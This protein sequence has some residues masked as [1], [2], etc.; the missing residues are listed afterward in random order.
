[1]GMM[2]YS[3]LLNRTSL[4]YSNSKS[5]GAINQSLFSNG[6]TN[7][8]SELSNILYKKIED[9]DYDF[10]KQIIEKYNLSYD[11]ME[12]IIK[13]SSFYDKSQVSIF[14]ELKKKIKL[15]YNN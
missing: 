8:T 5:W 12:K 3:T 14:T 1:M 6:D 7:I 15:Y 2:N 4:E 9:D 11:S 10:V 13:Y